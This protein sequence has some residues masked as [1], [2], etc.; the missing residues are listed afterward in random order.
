MTVGGGAGPRSLAR[1]AGLRLIRVTS[2]DVP[3][4]RTSSSECPDTSRDSKSPVFPPSWLRGVASGRPG[5]ARPGCRRRPAGAV[6][7]GPGP[8]PGTRAAARR[9][10]ELRT[11]VVTPAAAGGNDRRRHLPPGP[12]PDQPD[13]AQL[14]RLVKPLR[15]GPGAAGPVTA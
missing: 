12:E 11:Q 5:L 10:S 4:A 13:P 9:D 7:G 15:P 8:G 14:S 6:P 3:L 2:P 1:A